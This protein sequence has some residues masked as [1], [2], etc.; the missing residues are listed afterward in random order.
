MKG[1]HRI[2]AAEA[3]PA[4]AKINLRADLG[5]TREPKHINIQAARDM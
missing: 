1:W 5:P 4:S 2:A 3:W